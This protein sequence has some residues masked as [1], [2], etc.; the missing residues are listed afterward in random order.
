MTN[1]PFKLAKE[2][3]LGLANTLTKVTLTEFFMN[4]H[5][6]F[7]PGTD[8]TFMNY[9]L[10]LTA[11]EDEFYVH[12]SKLA[13]C[14]IMTSMQ[15]SDVRKKLQVLDLVESEDFTLRDV[16]ERGKSGS[17]IHKHYHLTPKAFKKCLMRAQRRANQPVDPII[18]CDYYL[19]LE[20]VFKLYT[21]YERAY[22]ER[23]LAMKDDKIDRLTQMNVD[24]KSTVEKQSSKIDDLLMY[25]HKTTA[26]LEATEA[27]LERN[28]QENAAAQARMI[29][30]NEDLAIN[31]RDVKAEQ[32]KTNKHLTNM[33]QMFARTTYS[34]MITQN[35]I[36]L[37][38]GQQGIVFDPVKPWNGVDNMKMFF[39]FAWTN[40]DG[41]RMTIQVACRNFC[42]TPT[43]LRELVRLMN[44]EQGKFIG[45]AAIGFV[46][47][48]V[49]EEKKL[50]DQ[51][52]EQTITG[53]TTFKRFNKQVG[54]DET[55][56]KL[57]NGYHSRLRDAFRLRHQR[58]I[59]RI[60]ENEG[61]DT[62]SSNSRLI[63]T[64]FIQF[65]ND[66]VAWCQE[67]LD[68]LIIGEEDNV[69]AVDLRSALKEHTFGDS[70][71]TLIRIHRSS[72]AKV[73][74]K[75]CI[76]DF[77]ANFESFVEDLTDSSDDE[78]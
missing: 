62:K 11:H 39:M 65:N 44:T 5:D 42:T 17:Q 56:L 3:A 55:A 67:Y 45:C 6:Q 33:A 37:F 23:S 34:A 68:S 40:E 57:F 13:E 27:I 10:E 63:E 21:D 50:F 75:I 36:E 59:A 4:I 73:Q 51:V 41:S 26:T 1:S 19:L 60:I 53:K 2:Y 48:D 15:S 69:R 66:T 7:Y 58:N 35:W 22:S 43:R 24:L 61:A 18:Y 64:H 25:G 74:L 20:D 38:S 54:N 49:N 76:R 52:F 9:F 29:T 16:S 77:N 46:D 12:H 78:K 30:Q 14:G 72:L 8:I 31:L 28:R 32:V 70:D 71:D 47:K